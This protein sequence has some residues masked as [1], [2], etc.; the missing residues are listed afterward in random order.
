[1]LGNVVFWV[2]IWNEIEVYKYLTNGIAMAA[3]LLLLGKGKERLTGISLEK[4][5]L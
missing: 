4:Y 2:L 1:M 5:S 3:M